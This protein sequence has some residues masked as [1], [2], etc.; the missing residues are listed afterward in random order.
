MQRGL[1]Q[2]GFSACLSVKPH[3]T[4]GAFVRPEINVTY[5]MGNEGPKIFL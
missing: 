2:L 1:L 3:L 5:S 4:S